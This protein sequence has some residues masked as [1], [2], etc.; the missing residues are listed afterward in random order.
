MATNITITLLHSFWSNFFHFNL[1]IIILV[2]LS[3]LICDN[4]FDHGF[5]KLLGNVF[6]T[7]KN[8]ENVV[9]A[10]LKIFEEQGRTMELIKRM[11][12]QEIDNSGKTIR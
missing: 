1:F 2:C 12:D 6:V 11:I 10:V 7:G 9:F 3:H 8:A 4:V 5:T